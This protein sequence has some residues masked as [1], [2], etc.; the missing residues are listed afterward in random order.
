MTNDKELSDLKIERKE[1]PRCGAAWINGK[2][3]FRGT[4]A[5]YD[6][7]ELDLAGLVCNNLGDE[8][9]INP[10]KGLEG[11]D[12]WERRLGVIDKK[13]QEEDS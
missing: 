13:L 12:S 6:K 4:A 2:H 3:V 11:G 5:S 10:M 1:C 8:T 9:C 7:S